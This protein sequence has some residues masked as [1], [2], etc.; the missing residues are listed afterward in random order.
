[1]RAAVPGRRGVRSGPGCAPGQRCG[2]AH[3]RLLFLVTAR[4]PP[5]PVLPEGTQLTNP[6]TAGREQLAAALGAGSRPAG[7]KL[8]D[9]AKA[10]SVTVYEAWGPHRR[11]AIQFRGR[12]PPGDLLPLLAPH[13]RLLPVLK[14][15]RGRSPA[16]PLALSGI[17][18]DAALIRVVNVP[19]PPRA[20]PAA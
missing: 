13:S 4:G 5:A 12:N 9:H 3:V 16:S 7:W 18:I 2:D 19:P 11:V 14:T 1:M 8:S 10:R 17:H 6:T 15:P 20:T